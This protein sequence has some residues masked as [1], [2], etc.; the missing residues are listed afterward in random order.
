MSTE[1]RYP[2]IDETRTALILNLGTEHYI[3]VGGGCDEDQG[4]ISFQATRADVDGGVL[5]KVESHQESIQQALGSLCGVS[6]VFQVLIC[7]GAREFLSRIL[8]GQEMPN[9]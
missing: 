1:H 4:G 9:H 6:A 8:G 2:V 3:R 7:G 5:A